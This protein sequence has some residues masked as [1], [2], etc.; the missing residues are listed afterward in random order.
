MDHAK[1]YRIK[2]RTLVFALGLMEAM[3]RSGNI[4]LKGSL[5]LLY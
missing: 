3:E 4:V 2:I 1:P 5:W